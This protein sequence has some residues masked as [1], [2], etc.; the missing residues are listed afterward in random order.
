MIAASALAVCSM[1]FVSC[2]DETEP[3]NVATE[4]QVAESATAQK[5]M[6]MG[7]H[8]YLNRGNSSLADGNTWH[9]AFGYSAIQIIRDLFT[10]DEGFNTTS[11]TSHFSWAS[12]NKYLGDGYLYMQYVWNYYYG[13]VLQAN[14]MIGSVDPE[15]ATD[16]QLGYLG[17]GYAFRSMIYLDL[18]RMYEFL[19]ND[20]TSNINKDGNDVL[21]LTVPIVTE[22]TTEEGSRNNPRVTRE[23][24][25][26][27]IENDLNKAEEYIVGM[28][29]D[30]DH[31]L[32]DLAC[33]YG[34]KARLYMWLE[35]YDKAQHYANL[36]ISASSVG[37]IS[38]SDALNVTSG[39]NKSTDFMWAAQLTKED[40]IVQT[41]I[42]NS[43]SWLSNQSTF[44]YT[45]AATGVYMLCDKNFYDRISDTD[46]RKLEF[47]GPKGSPLNNKI[48]YIDSYLGSL[49]PAYASVKFRPNSG[50]IENYSTGAAVAYPIMRVEEMYFIEAEAAAHQSA[51]SG[52][53]LIES[54]MKNY[55]DPNYV[56]TASSIDDVVEEIVFQ[57]RVEQWGEGQTFF[58]IK[59]LNYS[60]TRGYPG[61]PFFATMRFNTNGRPAWMN[62]VIVRTEANNNSALKGWNNPDPSDTYDPWQ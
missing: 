9:A 14:K 36:A 60:V 11:Y 21:N 29:A 7:L 32:P 42:V 40:Y 17:A 5:A 27:F 8:A 2:I 18:A 10:G 50:D 38:E 23:K 54:F 24:M 57:K 52:K 34:L 30:A 31:V 12:R 16:L 43:V 19:P 47:K 55:R 56:C 48:Q 22:E 35:Q 49:M 51:A 62:C 58:D 20:K 53:Q 26:E 15:N 4:D 33:V 28:P 37:P 59:R 44:G 6:L 13:F 46:W 1:T 61:T 41:G 45:G 39:F 25:A 3:T